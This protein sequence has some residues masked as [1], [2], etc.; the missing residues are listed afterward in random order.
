MVQGIYP[1]NMANMVQYL[2]FRI[3]EFPLRHRRI[4][5]VNQ[6]HT[7]DGCELLHQLNTVV[8]KPLFIGFQPSRWC[9]ISQPSTV[10]C[11][12]GN[13]YGIVWG[14]EPHEWDTSVNQRAGTTHR[15]G[16]AKGHRYVL[17]TIHGYLIDNHVTNMFSVSHFHH[18]QKQNWRNIGMEKG[19]ETI[20][21]VVSF[22]IPLCPLVPRCYKL[23]YTPQFDGST[24]N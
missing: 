17:P 22:C 16:M 11:N 4:C 10:S 1:Q 15:I 18:W 2:H 9:R 5:G 3:L 6:E 23:V 8:D 24:S 21:Y 7:V 12:S 14:F 19:T 20:S 13:Q